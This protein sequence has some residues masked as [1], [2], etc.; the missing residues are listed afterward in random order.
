MNVVVVQGVLSK[1]PIERTLPS[2]STV[3]DWS[4]SVEIAG[5]KQSVPVQWT[6]PTKK[7]RGHDKGDAVVVLGSVRQRF[8]FAGGNRVSRTEVV[9]EAVAKPTQRAGA[10]K[11]LE[12]ATAALTSD[13]S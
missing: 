12:R 9:G 8:F 1:E 6:D 2:G 10:R 4:V 7:V 3:M 13:A 5:T 11:I